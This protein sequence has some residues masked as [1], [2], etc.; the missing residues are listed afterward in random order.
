MATLGPEQST[1]QPTLDA[2]SVMKQALDV[3]HNN[4]EY[5]DNIY[6]LGPGIIC[7]SIKNAAG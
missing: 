4:Q 2:A 3:C 6:R 1:R 5:I 7:K